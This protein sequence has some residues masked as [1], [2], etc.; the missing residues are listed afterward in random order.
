MYGLLRKANKMFK[1]NYVKY[2]VEDMIYYIR[3]EL[4]S[5]I[6]NNGCEAARLLR[7]MQFSDL[8]STAEP[9]SWSSAAIRLMT[10]LTIASAYGPSS[11]MLTKSLTL[12]P[13]FVMNS[14]ADRM[15]QPSARSSSS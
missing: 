9:M 12:L 8:L 15:T 6:D 4:W 10:Y 11:K 1:E 13:T 5:S 2:A 7:L 14:S 3:E